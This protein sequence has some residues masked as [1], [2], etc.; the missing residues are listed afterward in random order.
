LTATLAAEPQLADLGVS[1]VAVRVAAVR[2]APETEKALE[3]P[4]REELQ[5][6]ADEATF[7]RRAEAVENERAIQENELKNRI[8]L[9]RREEAL[10]EQEGTNRRRDAE[11]EAERLRIAA[12]AEADRIRVTGSAETVAARELAEVYAA[13]PPLATIAL[14][15]R[16][17]A[18]RL[19]QIGQLVLTPDLLTALAGRL[20][21]PASDER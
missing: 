5:Q 7:R 14:A 9:A 20:A 1:V 4:T 8:E 12:R 13:S 19:P 18:E 16:E 15:A 3:L 11:Q 17:T 10:V 2:P 6:A 21:S